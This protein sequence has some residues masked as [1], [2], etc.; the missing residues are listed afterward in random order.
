MAA[1]IQ[2]TVRIFFRLSSSTVQPLR[3]YPVLLF[4]MLLVYLSNG[5]FI[6]KGAMQMFMFFFFKLDET[7]DAA[8]YGV[9]SLVGQC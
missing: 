6:F 3:Q 1:S 5:W 8:V 9:Y 2:R 7:L 4:I